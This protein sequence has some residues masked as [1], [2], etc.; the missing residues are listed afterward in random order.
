MTRRSMA[1]G[2]VVLLA[3]ALAGCHSQ[4]AAESGCDPTAFTATPA[5]VNPGAAVELTFSGACRIEFD[6]DT[7]SFLLT[8][9]NNP[10][11]QLQVAGVDGSTSTFQARITIPENFPEGE[12]TVLLIGTPFSDD[13]GV[14]AS[15]AGFS[16]TIEVGR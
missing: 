7:M 15:C 16:T 2:M 1:A 11:Y 4:R 12:A 14:D 6:A 3:A 8:N 5:I 13:C 9:S 10:D